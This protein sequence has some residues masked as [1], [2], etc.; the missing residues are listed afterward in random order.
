MKK[1]LKTTATFAFSLLAAVAWAG[2]PGE[3]CAAKSQSFSQLLDNHSMRLWEIELKPGHFADVHGHPGQKAYAATAG[4]LQVT[5]SEGK[6]EEIKVRAGDL[7][8]ADATKYK[9]ENKGS[10]AFK[11]IVYED[12]EAQ[13]QQGQNIYS[14][15]SQK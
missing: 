6:I 15:F 1:L 4:T 2:E 9:T 7:L 12:K 14:F 3:G 8:W 11:A 5:T 13:M 10:E